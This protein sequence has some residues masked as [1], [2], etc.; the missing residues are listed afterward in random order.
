ME[1]L[2]HVLPLFSFSKTAA[3]MLPRLNFIAGPCFVCWSFICRSPSKDTPSPLRLSSSAVS[4][5]AVWGEA[6]PQA[7]R[8]PARGGRALGGLGQVRDLPG[9]EAYRKSPVAAD[10][11]FS[12]GGSLPRSSRHERPA[13]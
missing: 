4:R 7:G 6:V 12:S 13:S 5:C 3:S 11:F 1:T 2:C 9:G 10:R 8:S